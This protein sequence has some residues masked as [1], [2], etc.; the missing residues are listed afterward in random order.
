MYETVDDQTIGLCHVEFVA[1]F[2]VNLIQ[3]SFD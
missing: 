3:I 2:V 1:V